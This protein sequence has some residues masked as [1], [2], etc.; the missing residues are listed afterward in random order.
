MNKLENVIQ[1]KLIGHGK[2]L[3]NI[4]ID[5]GKYPLVKTWTMK[6]S[7]LLQEPAK[8]RGGRLRLLA[9]RRFTIN[10]TM[11]IKKVCSERSNTKDHL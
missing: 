1:K 8:T 11:R 10:V 3:E 4:T 9:L 6:K 7:S 2:R 5:F